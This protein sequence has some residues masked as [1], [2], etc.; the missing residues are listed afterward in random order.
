M[1]ECHVTQP[2]ALV[3]ETRQ[4]NWCSATHCY[5]NSTIFVIIQHSIPSICLLVAAKAEEKKSSCTSPGLW[6]ALSMYNLWGGCALKEKWGE[7]KKKGRGRGEEEKERKERERRRERGRGRGEGEEGERRGREVRTRER[8]PTRH[9]NVPLIIPPLTSSFLWHTC[10]L[11]PCCF[12]AV[13]ANVA[14]F[15]LYKLAARLLY[16]ACASFVLQP[17]WRK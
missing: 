11:V 13:A 17:C 10:T 6:T 3:Y 14:S 15:S 9:K 4:F 16:L 12:W 2:A 8:K 7:R 5:K 1:H